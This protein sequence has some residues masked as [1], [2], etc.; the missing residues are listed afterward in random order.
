MQILTSLLHF[1]QLDVAEAKKFDFPSSEAGKFQELR[2]RH[3][4]EC[5][6]R[7]GGG[8]NCDAGLTGRN[9]S[10]AFPCPFKS[11]GAKPYQSE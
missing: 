11:V 7:V 2:V 10:L 8:G 4:K 3:R 1:G 9:R 6:L 5:S